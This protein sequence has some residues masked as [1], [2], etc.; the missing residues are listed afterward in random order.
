M[1]AAI[2]ANIARHITLTAAEQAVF[3]SL[4]VPAQVPRFAYVLRAGEPSRYLTFVARGCVRTFVTDALGREAVLSFAWEGWWCGGA[5]STVPG[6]PA[7][8]SIQALETTDVWHLGF[9][10]LEQLCQQVP[11]FEHFFRVLFR[12]GFLHEQRR[13]QAL[14]QESAPER[15]TRFCRRH[16]RLSQRVALKYIASYL[17]MTPEFLSALRK[18][19]SV[20]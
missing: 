11:A 4:L 20:S 17:G 18:K 7:T 8:V 16:P 9:A 1:R 10:Q 13:L 5:A 14:L 15:Y 19:A 6:G 3:T 2:L 12:Q